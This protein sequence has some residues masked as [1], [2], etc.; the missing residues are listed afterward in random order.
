MAVR[1]TFALLGAR[2]GPLISLVAL[3]SLPYYVL[4]KG[5]VYWGW[6]PAEASEVLFGF[7]ALITGPITNATIVDQMHH[8]KGGINVPLGRSM[9]T[10]IRAYP[11]MLAA[12]I[13]LSFVVLGWLAVSILPG[14]LIM[15]IFGLKSP[16]VLI[17]FGF[18][19]LL[20]ALPP[21]AFLDSVLVVEGLPAWRARQESRTLTKGRRPAIIVFGILA[22]LPAAALELGADQLPA[23]MDEVFSGSTLL[24]AIALGVISSA[25]YMIPVTYFYVLYTEAKANPSAVPVAVPAPSNG[26]DDDSAPHA[27]VLDFKRSKSPTSQ[28]VR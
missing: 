5:V 2:I 19:G 28:D 3:L 17:P 14:G 4:Y 24:A 8:A 13:S 22:L 23:Y 1:Q 6:L 7:V 18:V 11:R 16:L 26:A 21:Y 25:L 10:G 20:F 12:Y 27:K 9:M 15:L